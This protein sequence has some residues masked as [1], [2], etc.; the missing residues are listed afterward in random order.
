[1]GIRYVNQSNTQVTANT[2]TVSP[3]ENIV[4]IGYCKRER[5]GICVI[6]LLF[7]ML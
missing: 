6:Y 7:Y 2:H 1:M 5:G 4:V 3:C